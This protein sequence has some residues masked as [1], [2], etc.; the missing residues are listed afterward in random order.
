[1]SDLRPPAHDIPMQET[2]PPPTDQAGLAAQVAWLT[3]S[4]QMLI[5][6]NE[7]YR[8][9]VNSLRQEI[10]EVRAREAEPRVH[11][12]KVADPPMFG[13]NQ[14]ELEGW[15]TACR[16]KFAGQPSRFP[17]ESSKVIFAASFLSGPPKTWIQPLVTAYLSEGPEPKPKEFT[18][19][20]RFIASLKTLYRDPNLE[21]NA[22][23]ALSVME[24]TSSVAE[25]ISRFTGLSQ[26]T[27][28]NDV[29]LMQYFY[30]GLKKTIK[31]ELA[32]RDYSTLK[33]LQTLATKLDARLH[34]R[35]IERNRELQSKGTSP[36]KIVLPPKPGASNHAPAVSLL[37]KSHPSPNV[38]APGTLPTPAWDGSSPM[39]LDSQQAHRLMPEERMRRLRLG[40]CWNCGEHGHRRFDCPKL[41]DQSEK[42][43][44]QE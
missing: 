27:R 37:Y 13:G 32:T 38:P 17:R 9:E 22:M 11:E 33:E 29:G 35:T 30:K 10:E 43:Q 26:Y 6:A 19:F 2:P 7:T 21:R 36:F 40:L 20:E 31:D 23:S 8:A 28:L 5:Q 15:I 12:P 24:Q 34:E 18:S 16:L 41:L 4:L 25:Y 14:K 1:M 39:E 42:D 44:A 3:E